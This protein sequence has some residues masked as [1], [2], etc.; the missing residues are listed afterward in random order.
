METMTKKAIK[1]VG[2]MIGYRLCPV[3]RKV[4]TPVDSNE[5]NGFFYI[6]YECGDIH[7][8]GQWLEKKPLHGKGA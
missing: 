3:C 6:W 7:C 1:V 8:D 2:G 5:E 4:M